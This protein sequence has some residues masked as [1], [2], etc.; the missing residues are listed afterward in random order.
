MRIPQV[1][2]HA[3]RYNDVEHNC[4][5]ERGD[6]TINIGYQAKESRW[7]MNGS[8]KIDGPQGFRRRQEDD[9][10]CK[11]HSVVEWSQFR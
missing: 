1:E 5:A 8:P 2:Y 10:I 4:W 9:N 3:A 11:I 6:V 7:T